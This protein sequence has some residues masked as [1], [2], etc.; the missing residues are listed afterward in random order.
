MSFASRLKSARKAAGLSQTALAEKIGM[1]QTAIG[2]MEQGKIKQPRK[3]NE[4]AEVLEVSKIWLQF[5]NEINSN[6]NLSKSE[7][8]LITLYRNL[9]NNDKKALKRIIKGLVIQSKDEK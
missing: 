5:G 8:E 9:E 7:K 3:L 6:T 1:D 4:I 2:Q